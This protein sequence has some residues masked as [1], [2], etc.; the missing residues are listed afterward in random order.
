MPPL[1]NLSPPGNRKYR[2]YGL[3][4]QGQEDFSGGAFF[5]Q[6]RVPANGCEDIVNGYVDPDGGVARRGGSQYRGVGLPS[7][8]NTGTYR[9]MMFWDGY[10]AAGRRTVQVRRDPSAPSESSDRILV[11]TTDE[12]GWV[13]RG[14]GLPSTK[15]R[16]VAV[17]GVLFYPDAKTQPAIN[18][19]GSNLTDPGASV[20]G[21]I[22]F[23]QGSAKVTGTGT[24]FTSSVVPGQVLSAGSPGGSS[25]NVH[26]FGVQAVVSDTELTLA[27]AWQGAN[28]TF[29]ASTWGV[30]SQAYISTLY[31]T[32]WAN[33]APLAGSQA[34]P[35]VL[36]VTAG[37]LLIGRGDRVAFSDAGDPGL[38]LTTNYHQMP[39]GSLVTGIEGVRDSALV[40]TTNGVMAIRNLSYDLTDAQGNVQQT[41]QPLHP[42]LVLWGELGLAGWAGAVIVPGTDGVYM[43]D[44]TSSPVDLSNEAIQGLYRGYVQAGYQPGLA[45]VFQSRYF[46]PILNGD[47]WVDTLVCDLRSRSWSRLDGHGGTVSFFARRVNDPSRQPMLLGLE[48]NP[49]QRM[50]DLSGFF[51]PSSTVKNDANGTTHQLKLTFRTLTAGVIPVQ[52]RKF[53]VRFEADDAASDDPQLQAEVATGR[54]GNPFTT[55]SGSAP[56]GETTFNWSLSKKAR[57]VRYRVT[58]LHPASKFVVRAFESFY[59]PSGRT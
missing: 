8:Y 41:L 56:E 38:W 10:L 15:A 45:S 35:A 55:L 14:T 9:P 20:T 43:V 32:T 25:A 2:W 54:P 30:S 6:E 48:A 7:P 37:R 3:I 12:S 17:A 33:T 5:G 44:G 34:G 27:A 11:E 52:W 24:N 13:V 16:M 58:T 40:F 51:A 1:P 18:Y 26:L 29:S 22:A 19:V 39:A 46:L 36:G 59:R 21:S 53:R 47:A 23:T 42:E 57:A 31:N 4:Q 49:G 50:L 28:A